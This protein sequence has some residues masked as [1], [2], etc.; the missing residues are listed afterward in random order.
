MRQNDCSVREGNSAI[1]PSR[2]HEWRSHV[3]RLPFHT[4]C[5]SDFHLH[6][7]KKFTP[8]KGV[9]TAVYSLSHPRLFRHR[10][11]VASYRPLQRVSIY[12]SSYDVHDALLIHKPFADTFEANTL[13]TPVRT[14]IILIGEK[15]NHEARRYDRLHMLQCFSRYNL[16]P[17]G[18]IVDS[19]PY[20]LKHAP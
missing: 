16:A 9:K 7:L 6:K 14:Q 1:D 19:K 20:T 13:R 4:R 8:P 17:E 10:L 5:C 3:N 15:A 11:G 18:A 12:P 2:F